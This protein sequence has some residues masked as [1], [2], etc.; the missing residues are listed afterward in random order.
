MV[1]WCF[2]RFVSSSVFFCCS[3]CFGS[4]L[5]RLFL[6]CWVLSCWVYI[7]VLHHPYTLLLRHH[8]RTNTYEP[9]KGLKLTSPNRLVC[10][11]S[12][13][14]LSSLLLPVLH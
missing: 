2:I 10:L 6:C 1:S 3:M 7:S 8:S 5:F 11:T 13:L 9:L 12:V 4:G 14:F